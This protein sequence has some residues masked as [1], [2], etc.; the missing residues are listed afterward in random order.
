MSNYYLD[1]L[2]KQKIKSGI[3][4]NTMQEIEESMGKINF[5]IGAG[6]GNWEKTGEISKQF[7]SI[8]AELPKNPQIDLIKRT[9]MAKSGE[10]I[11]AELLVQLRSILTTE[12]AKKKLSEG[13]L[14]DKLHKEIKEFLGITEVEL[15]EQ[16]K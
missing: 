14:K 15:D 7:K 16:K 3:T 1:K 6:L 13:E 12:R 10:N 4:A 2:V 5:Y 9:L 11:E 8:L